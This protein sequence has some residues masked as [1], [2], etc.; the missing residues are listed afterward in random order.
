LKNFVLFL[1]GAIILVTGISLILLWW[2]QVVIVFQ[3]AIGIILALVGL[4][5]LA[6]IKG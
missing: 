2:P 4:I 3:G 1:I 6:L 5:A